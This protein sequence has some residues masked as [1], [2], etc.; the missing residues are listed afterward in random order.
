MNNKK[1]L[2]IVVNV[3]W[4]FISHRL[5]IAV[6]A[7][8]NGWKVVVAT[9]DTGRANEI[10]QCGIQF[11]NIPIK[12]S[13]TNPFSEIK[14]VY[15][16][17]K[18][19]AKIR[20]NVMHHI[21]L[22]P[23]IYGTVIARLLKIKGVVN[24]ISGLGFNFINQERKGISKIILRLMDV[25]FKRKMAF[26]F[27]NKDD[28]KELQKTAILKSY[29]QVYFI[30]GSGVD[31][32]LYENLPTE[33]KEKT[34]ILFAARL[35]WSK[36]VK[37]LK[38]ATDILKKQY[39]NNVSFLIC[40]RLDDDAKDAVSASFMRNWC[41]GKFVLW[42]GYV[43]EMLPI[44]SQC[45]LVVFPSYRE[46]MPKS[47][48]EACAAG[49]PI[50]TTNAVGCKECVDEGV[51][52]FKVPVKSVNELVAALKKL[53]ENPELRI[54]MGEASRK[55]AEEE[56]DQKEVVKKHLDIYNNLYKTST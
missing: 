6:E 29:H 35:L 7:V 21:T 43:E 44:Y 54:K 20:P 37:E 23:V 3:D 53:I 40:G 19:Y 33:K 50:V 31:L 11:I 48:L 9:K 55:K 2:L 1:T 47:L 30:K 27:Q 45:D 22:K 14:L 12:R 10:T 5:P 46:G 32:D 17:F 25:S 34:V 36:G 56:F 16:L 15:F 8:K 4:F 13:G 52:G 51:N 28:Y 38:A 42:D 49:K 24:A 18:T 41:D 26:I 39:K